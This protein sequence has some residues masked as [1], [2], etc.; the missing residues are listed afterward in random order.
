MVNPYTNW[1][2]ISAANMSSTAAGG[3]NANTAVN[4]VVPASPAIKTFRF[5]NLIASRLEK[6]MPAMVADVPRTLNRL[7][8]LA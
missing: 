2:S 4:T 6:K 3:M 7:N 8:R 1:R 5:P